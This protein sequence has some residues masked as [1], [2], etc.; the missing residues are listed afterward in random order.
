MQSVPL[1]PRPPPLA[2]SVEKVFQVFGKPE[3]L[4]TDILGNA[5][6]AMGKVYEIMI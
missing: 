4:P 1:A 6:R 5:L 2:L 3:G